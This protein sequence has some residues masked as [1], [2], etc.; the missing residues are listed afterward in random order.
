M[1]T[2]QAAFKRLLKTPKQGWKYAD[3]E[4]GLASLCE[5]LGGHM[6]MTGLSIWQWAKG[7]NIT[8]NALLGMVCRAE[9]YPCDFV[10]AVLGNEPF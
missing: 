4:Q 7:Q 2:E 5:I 3:D 8:E 1:T 10:A 9:E 6:C